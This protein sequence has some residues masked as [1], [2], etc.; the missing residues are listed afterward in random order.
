MRTEICGAS[1]AGARAGLIG[2]GAKKMQVRVENLRGV[3]YPGACLTY[4]AG[5]IISEGVFSFFSQTGG[6][7]T[8]CN[9]G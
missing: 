7:K 9:E 2:A 1:W 4:A 8:W 5:N 3:R 6:G